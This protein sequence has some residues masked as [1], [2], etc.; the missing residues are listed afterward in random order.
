MVITAT[1]E[2]TIGAVTGTVR[3][4]VPFITIEPIIE[5]L[6]PQYWY[7]SVRRAGHGA[8]GPIP[9]ELLRADAEIA[10]R[11]LPLTLAQL[12]GIAAGEPVELPALAHGRAS[13]YVGGELL[14]ELAVDP[15]QTSGQSLSVPVVSAE[16]PDGSGRR[17]G[18]GG[19][20]VQD[21]I[22]R[23]HREIVQLRHDVRVMADN[24]RALSDEY[25]A[26]EMDAGEGSPSGL[27][28]SDA[29]T[30]SPAFAPHLATVLQPERDHAVAFCLSLLAPETAAGVLADV[31][32]S[33]RASVVRALAQLEE[34][35]E[36]FR[37]RIGA[38]LVRAANARE[39]ATRSGG[40]DAV[41]EVLNHVPRSV[42]KSVMEQFMAEEKPLFEE[43]AKRMFV[44]EDFV[45][46]D[47]QAIRK[48][49]ARVSVEEMAPAMKDVQADVASHI[50]N[51]LDEDTAAALQAAI[52]ATGR[53]RRRDV[54]AAQRELIEELRVLEESGE[55]VVGRPDEV[56]D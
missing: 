25:V 32:P 41:A 10:T 20:A 38:Y 51:A 53:V 19:N 52:D 11:T 55:I 22:E 29:R 4:C 15:V 13:L 44:F 6:S 56:I 14:A 8:H 12:S 33:R 9:A 39:R 47:A 7:S 26:Q 48:L 3:F 34:V 1:M 37:V 5:K 30:V 49:A 24:Q 43:I 2:V 50:L 42:E 46:V 35:E 36:Q 45:L 18:N 21:G 40:Y 54:E 16:P 28:G 31:E 23:L 27:L 17:G